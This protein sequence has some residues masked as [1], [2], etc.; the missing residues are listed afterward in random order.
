MIH[1]DFKQIS[2][3][4]KRELLELSSIRQSFWT[5]AFL[6]GLKT[7]RTKSSADITHV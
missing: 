5:A 2:S 6:S 7:P 1:V 3:R 4:Y